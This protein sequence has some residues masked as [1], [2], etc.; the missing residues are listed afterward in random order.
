MSSD[1]EKPKVGVFKL[2]SCAGCQ[3]VL[4]YHHDYLP[5]ILGAV[6]ITNF[7]MARRDNDPEGKFDLA[8]VEGAVTE[9]EHVKL[10]KELRPRTKLLVAMG[11]CACDGGVLSMKNSTP[12]YQVES[13]VYTDTS[14]FTSTKTQPV[15]DIVKV[16]A[17]ARGCPVDGPELLELLKSA[18]AGKKPNLS[19]YSVCMECKVNENP[20]L[21]TNNKDACMGPITKGGCG[22]LC[23]TN[24]R[25]CRGCRGPHTDANI[26]SY[27]RSVLDREIPGREELLRKR[28]LAEF[29]P[30]NVFPQGRNVIKATEVAIISANIVGKKGGSSQ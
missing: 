19:N 8:L 28:E 6:D 5:Q 26:I 15:D 7:K 20:C 21:Y 25:A 13:A 14:K 17:Y 10:L 12:E 11:S 2:S 23:P 24:A 27:A 18:L 16:D 3:M 30:P 1:V 29:A 9:P 22:A 4:I